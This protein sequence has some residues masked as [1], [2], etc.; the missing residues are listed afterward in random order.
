[1]TM[2]H[3]I[4]DDL[5]A[6][7]GPLSSFLLLTW[8]EGSLSILYVGSGVLMLGYAVIWGSYYYKSKRKTTHANA[9]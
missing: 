4:L 6:A 8:L 9:A 3:T 5:G 7:V 1:M 2:W